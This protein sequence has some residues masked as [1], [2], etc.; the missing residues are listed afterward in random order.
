MA[1]FIELKEKFDLCE[2]WRTRSPKTKR[3]TLRQKHVSGLIQRRLD[4][5]TFLISC[6][7]LS[8]ILTFY[9]CF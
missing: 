6:K 3:Y 1:K 5:F 2:I 9:L 8:K 4:I 7:S